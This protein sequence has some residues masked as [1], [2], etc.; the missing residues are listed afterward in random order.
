[1]TD[2]QLMHY[3]GFDDPELLTQLKDEYNFS[4]KSI[5]DLFGN[6]QPI[7]TYK[8]S[9]TKARPNKANGNVWYLRISLETQTY[10]EIVYYPMNVLMSTNERNISLMYEHVVSIKYKNDVKK[11]ILR[12][13]EIEVEL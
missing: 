8:A 1:M 2:E 4:H 12:T 5:I 6:V 3:F 7:I 9:K 10:N 13:K 11:K